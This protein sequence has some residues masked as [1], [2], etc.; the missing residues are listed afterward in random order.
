[1]YNQGSAGTE[2]E[3]VQQ[4]KEDVTGEAGLLSLSV[5]TVLC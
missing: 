1:M 3:E 5:D 4:E 2:I